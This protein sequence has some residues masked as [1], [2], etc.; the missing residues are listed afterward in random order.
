MGIYGIILGIVCLMIMYWNYFQMKKEIDNWHNTKTIQAKGRILDFAKVK[1]N[2]GYRKLEYTYS[3]ANNKA[4]TRKT[5]YVYRKMTD[6]E[7]D[8][9]YDKEYPGS[10]ITKP[11]FESLQKAMQN[12]IALTPFIIALFI[13]ASILR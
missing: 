9:L 8:I 7:V 11:E 12:T 6:E 4:Y 13:A 5:R 10:S 2:T 3:D 1:G